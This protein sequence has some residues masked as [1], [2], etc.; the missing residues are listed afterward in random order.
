MD[1]WYSRGRYPGAHADVDGPLTP[2]PGY[3]RVPPRPPDPYDRGYGTPSRGTPT[4]GNREIG[5]LHANVAGQVLRDD[6]VAGH[7]SLAAY[8]EA[9]RGNDLL[10]RLVQAVE[11]LAEG[12]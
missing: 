9:R 4:V 3:D 10:E 8:H 7:L 2:P 1:D 11:R 12:R 6:D 5:A